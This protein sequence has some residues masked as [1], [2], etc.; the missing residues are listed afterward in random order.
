MLEDR[1]ATHWLIS[2]WTYGRVEVQFQMMQTRGPFATEAKRVELLNHLNAI[3]GIHLPADAITRR[4][5]VSLATLKDE[6]VM[7]R[8]LAT[9]DWVIQEVRAS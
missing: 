2:V 3:P 9:L 4:P 1:E 5:A 8:F 7:S 6:A